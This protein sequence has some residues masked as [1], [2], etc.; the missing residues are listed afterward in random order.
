MTVPQIAEIVL[1]TAFA[2]LGYLLGSIPFGLVLTRL[3]GLGDIRDIGSGNIG[4]TNVLRTGRKDLALA[5]L[6]LDAGK[7]GIAYFIGF[8]ATQYLV[9]NHVPLGFQVD[10]WSTPHTVGLIAGAAAFVGHCY[11]VWLKFK[12]GK[13]VATYVG[14]LLAAMWQVGLAFC[15]I[16]L[17]TAA[18][19]RMSSFAALAATLAAPA[20]AYF[21]E[22]S[23]D[24]WIV[25]A[26]LAVLIY[27]R[28]R[29]N[30]SRILAG[31]EPKIGAKKSALPDDEVPAGAT[32]DTSFVRFGGGDVSEGGGDGGGD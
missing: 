13:G 9:R 5:T 16:W 8:F 15:A 17:L 6:L 4:A 11:P 14:L 24:G 12:G 29:A 28:H 18:L 7:A 23:G 21:L 1:C 2:L 10:L 19:F 26:A 22:P 20:I 3:A 31:T 32:R 27:W 25:M 30:I